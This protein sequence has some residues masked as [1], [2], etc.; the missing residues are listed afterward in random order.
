MKT[1]LLLITLLTFQLVGLSQNIEY[2]YDDAGNR[3]LRKVV[4]LQQKT[5]KIDTTQFQQDLLGKQIV[6]VY[7][8]PT[9]GWLS[10]NINHLEPGEKSQLFVYSMSGAML[11]R[12]EDISTAN[13]IDLN[14]QSPGMYI[15]R[16]ILGAKTS[17]WKIIKK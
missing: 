7:P 16:I 5:A 12:K 10:V 9:S 15:M 8:N 17:E 13:R 14:A 11:I 4:V 2:K 6:K 1:T 3:I